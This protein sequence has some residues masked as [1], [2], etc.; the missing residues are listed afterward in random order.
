MPK[1]NI[2]IKYHIKYQPRI[3]GLRAVAVLA[4]LLFHAFPIY[5]SGGFIGVDIFFVISGYL[6]TSIILTDLEHSR[7]TFSEFYARRVRRIFPALIVVMASCLSFGYFRLIPSEFEQLGKH[8]A[9]GAI[10]V[11]NILLFKESGYFDVSAATKPLLHLWSL[12]IEEQ[13]YILWPLFAIFLYKTPRYILGGLLAVLLAS[14]FSS[15]NSGLNNATA[16]FYMPTYRFWELLLG[17]IL[18]V[19]HAGYG[20]KIPTFL[21]NSSAYKFLTSN[22]SWIGIAILVIAFTLIDKSKNFPG[23]WALLPTVGALLLIADSSTCWI[24]EKVMSNKALVWVGKISYPLYLWHWPLL[25]FAYI[26]NDAKQLSFMMTVSMLLLSFF[27]AYVTYVFVEKPVR[28]GKNQQNTIVYL[29]SAMFVLFIIGVTIKATNGLP[30]RYSGEMKDIAS[31]NH[32]HTDTRRGVCFLNENQYFSEMEVEC[33]E[34]NNANQ[35]LIF[36][37]GDSH[38]A[39]TYPGLKKA[40]SEDKEK[41]RLAQYTSSGCPPFLDVSSSWRVNC[42]ANNDY[43]IK[44]LKEDKPDTVILSGY[45]V[46][47]GENNS[48][49]NLRKT[50]AFL[51]DEGVNKIIIIGALPNWKLSVPKIILTQWTKTR[52]IPIRTNSFLDL[53][54]MKINERLKSLDS[55]ERVIFLSPTDAMCDEGACMLTV[56]SQGKLS[57]MQWDFTHLSSEGSIWLIE[58]FRTAIFRDNLLQ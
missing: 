34:K 58:Y 31:Y 16:A 47:Y 48:L 39:S 37:W 33:T 10:F 1:T 36:L 20:V 38:A 44:K 24:K 17:A 55:E 51:K 52:E 50:I 53:T 15:T 13:F 27:L 6:I 23:W 9:G 14:L 18:A 45:W 8:I 21:I 35:K 25:T 56:N 26:E 4:V 29:C 57:P 7:F 43:I 46:A 32:K 30:Q 12:G 49:L 11:S 54:P 5:F 28:F 22:L 19:M 42:K 41:Y 3:D 2:H 40:T